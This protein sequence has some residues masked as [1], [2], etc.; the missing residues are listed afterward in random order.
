VDRVISRLDG[1]G[2]TS[3]R[4][5]TRMVER[6]RERGIR[7]EVV[8]DVM[9]S[10]PRHLFVDEALASRAYDDVSL[11]LGFGQTISAPYTVARM[12]EALRGGG[13]LD[14]V[15]E[16]GTGCGYQTAV[17]ARLAREVYSVER[18]GELNARARRALREVRVTNI[19]LKHGDGSLGIPEAAPFDG[20]IVTAA[21]THVPKALL[22]Q[23]APGGRMAVPIGSQEQVLHLFERTDEGVTETTLESVKFVPLLPGVVN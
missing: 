6:L 7:D 4:T 3:M 23:L 2:M 8:L 11:P 15:L 14:K 17:L 9:G 20:I 22:E 16:V 13:D 10:V 5:R 1:I 12:T 19:R 21:V 18:I